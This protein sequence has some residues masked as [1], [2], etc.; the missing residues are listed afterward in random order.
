C[1]DAAPTETLDRPG[2]SAFYYV[3]LLSAQKAPGVGSGE[4]SSGATAGRIAFPLFVCAGG[5]CHHA[6]PRASSAERIAFDFSTQTD[7]GV[8]AAAVA[9][10]ARKKAEPPNADVVAV[11]QCRSRVGAV[12]AARLFRFQCVFASK[13]G[14]EVALHARESS[15]GEIGGASR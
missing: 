3:L 7:S 5:V 10:H 13:G 6:R 12:L 11:S 4:N 2:R 9:A 8:Q 1:R 15:R 14:R